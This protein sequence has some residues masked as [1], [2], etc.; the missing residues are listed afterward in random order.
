MPIMVRNKAKIHS[1]YHLHVGQ[2]SP[3]LFTNLGRLSTF[4]VTECSWPKFKQEVTIDI[5]GH[6][7]I[8]K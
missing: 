4:T 5:C 8:K 1:R 3:T 6:S 2:W 7:Q